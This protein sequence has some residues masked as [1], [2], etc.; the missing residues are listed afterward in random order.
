MRAFFLFSWCRSFPDLSKKK[1]EELKK[2]G[3]KAR[4]TQGTKDD[5]KTRILYR[6]LLICTP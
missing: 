4:Q 3:V 5:K 6:L 1:K 2:H